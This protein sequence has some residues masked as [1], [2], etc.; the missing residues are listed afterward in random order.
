VN[1]VANKV[2]RFNKSQNVW[3]LI[4]IASMYEP[5]RSSGIA[6]ADL[7]MDDP[8]LTQ[9]IKSVELA[10]SYPDR[11]L[12]VRYNDDNDRALIAIEETPDDAHFM[13]KVLSHALMQSTI[14]TDVKTNVSYILPKLGGKR[15]ENW[16]KQ[17]DEIQETHRIM[18]SL[19]SPNFEDPRLSDFFVYAVPD[20]NSI[21][22]SRM[23]LRWVMMNLK[24][25]RAFN[26]GD[27]LNRA[28]TIDT[29]EYEY[30]RRLSRKAMMEDPDYL[31]SEN[32]DVMFHYLRQIV[33]SN[34][35][36]IQN[37]LIRIEQ[38]Q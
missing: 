17:Y 30:L 18:I 37:Q 19:Y 10:L 28:V 3:E 25:G 4:G 7:V 32:R 31:K 9:A 23:T 8:R 34:G 20:Q 2:R 26:D 5:L 21:G 13:Y 35:A 38:K 15:Q 27:S 24:E 14:M 36:A 22:D 6:L 29:K 33:L 1:Q 12:L 11:F 16:S